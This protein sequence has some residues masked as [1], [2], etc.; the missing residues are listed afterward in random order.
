MLDGIKVP[1]KGA[2]DKARPT[3]AAARQGGM[4]IVMNGGSVVMNGTSEP[5]RTV[6][7][8]DRRRRSL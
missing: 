1:A 7:R 8:L 3:T 6:G 4:L 2:P 5:C